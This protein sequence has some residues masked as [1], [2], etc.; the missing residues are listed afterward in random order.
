MLPSLGAGTRRKGG[1]HG[2]AEYVELGR[3][4]DGNAGWRTNQVFLGIGCIEGS[5]SS[6]CPFGQSQPIRVE[7]YIQV[8]FSGLYETC[9]KCRKLV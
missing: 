4:L 5:L 9:P 3:P 8:Q 6:Y 1:R 2:L 7:P